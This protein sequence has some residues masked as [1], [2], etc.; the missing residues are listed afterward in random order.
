MKYLFLL[1]FISTSVEC[2]TQN[3]LVPATNIFD[4]KRLKVGKTEMTYYALAEGK[5]V[6]IGS[7]KVDIASNN[8]NISIYTTLQLLH[9]NDIWIDTCISEAGTFKPIYRSSFSK[10]N[11]YV[12]NYANE[13][14]GYYFNK[15]TQKR[16]IIKEPVKDIFFDN[17]AYPYFLG[18]LPLTA[19]YKKDLVVYDY[20]PDNK[21]N[22]QKAHIDK[23][24]SSTYVSTLT[25]E[26]NVWQVEVFEEASNSLYVYHIDKET[27]KIWKI[28]ITTK[29]QNLVLIDKEPE[30]NPF[31]N[32]F[33]KE[34]TLKL[35]NNGSSVISGQAFARDNKNG[36]ALQGMAVLN[37]NKKQFAAKGTEIILLPYTDFFK[38]WLKLNEV[39]K[40][41]YMQPIP[42]PEGANECIKVSEV[43]NDK[44]DFEFV[45]LMPG[46]Y[47]LT[48]KFIYGHSATETKV[49]GSTDTYINGVYQGSNDIKEF[50]S[51]IA[52]ATANVK[53]IITIKKDDEKVSV[54]LKKTL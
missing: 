28:E 1:L 5:L 42:L 2:K 18:L 24:K 27:R 15:K 23:V 12:L 47:L 26:H 22:I 3:I 34:E 30:F 38:E 40:K 11:N 21:S 31:V 49:V 19:G 44:G 6:E 7:Y 33:N 39:R 17:Y 43:Y 48:I 53:K 4:N 46:E 9:S 50:N 14:S 36:G 52:E 10:D 29:D 25:G 37:V 41:K 16:N 35:V 8:K 45:S 13:V 51:F 20:K 32:K 54:K